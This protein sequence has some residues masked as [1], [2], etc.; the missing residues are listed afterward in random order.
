MGGRGIGRAVAR[1]AAECGWDIA[2]NYREREEAANSP[3]REVEA[4]GRHA[5]AI[6]ADIGSES[7]IVSLFARA[8]ETLGP[9]SG[10]V[11]SA[12]IRH[13]NRVEALKVTELE[14]MFSVNVIGLMLCCR[15]AAKRMSTKNGGAGGSIVNV[16]SM[17]ATNGGR[18]GNSR[19]AA[20]QRAVDIF[21]M[22]FSKEVG[23]DAV[24]VNV[25]RP[26]LI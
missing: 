25:V 7:D 24:R 4:L 9:I 14:R 18:F 1:R 20:S 23:A 22:G 3:V 12:G 5:V 2:I 19:Y 13:Q 11:N 15:E 26:I 17:A 16:S 6:E 21:T 10:L 8:E